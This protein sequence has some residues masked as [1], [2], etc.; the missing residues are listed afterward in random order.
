LH[1]VTVVLD[2]ILASIIGYWVEPE[3]TGMLV[4]HTLLSPPN[5]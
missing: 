5:A 3:G 4:K 1:R 2:M